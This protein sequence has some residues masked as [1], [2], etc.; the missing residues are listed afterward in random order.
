[1]SARNRGAT[2]VVIDGRSRDTPGILA[3][4][5]PCF[6]RRRYAQDQRTRGTVVDFRCPSRSAASTSAPAMPSSATWTASS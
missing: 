6:S 2:G 1:M 4:G 5:F 3:L